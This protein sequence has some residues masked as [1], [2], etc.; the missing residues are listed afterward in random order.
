MPGFKLSFILE[1][2][3]VRWIPLDSFLK[4]FCFSEFCGA[5]DEGLGDGITLTGLNL[6]GGGEVTWVL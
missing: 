1:D 2:L 6:D 4:L 3:K 5:G